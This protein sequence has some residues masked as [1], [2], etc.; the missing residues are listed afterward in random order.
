MLTKLRFRFWSWA[1]DKAEAL[2][3]WIYYRKLL[4]LTPKPVASEPLLY[5]VE[6]REATAAE[7]QRGISHVD[8]YRS[9]L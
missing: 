3:H 1:H 7:E 2:W 4:P 6:S 5:F 9:P 8:L